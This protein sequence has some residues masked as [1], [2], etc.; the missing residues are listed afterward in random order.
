MGKRAIVC[1]EVD[2]RAFL[3]RAESNRPFSA[4]RTHPRLGTGIIGH[5]EYRLGERP[6]VERRHEDAGDAVLDELGDRSYVRGDDW[7]RHHHRLFD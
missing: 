7:A 4:E 3:D 5:A 6:R 1:L 2:A